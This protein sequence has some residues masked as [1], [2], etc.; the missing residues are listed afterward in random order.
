MQKSPLIFGIVPVVVLS[1]CVH[2][3]LGQE[4]CVGIITKIED[5]PGEHYSP[6]KGRQ[7]LYSVS[8]RLIRVG[9]Q[10]STDKIRILVLELYNPSRFGK[11]GDIL[12]F[13]CPRTSRQRGEVWFEELTGYKIAS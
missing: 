4:T 8:V 13:V 5:L 11:E 1:A 2:A 12:H 9:Y 6:T 3:Q 10:D 7:P